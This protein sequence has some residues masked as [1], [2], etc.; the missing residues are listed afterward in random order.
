M[1]QK[2]T[3]F[4]DPLAAVRLTDPKAIPEPKQEEETVEAPIKELPPMIA[5]KVENKVAEYEVLEMR[6]VCIR[7]QFST[8]KLGK[9]VSEASHGPGIIE[10][11]QKMG[12]K[13][14]LVE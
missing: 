6:R 13:L 8:F 1:S 2:K 7:G 14:K 11:L 10:M 12:V 9:K 4:S 5:A 3:N